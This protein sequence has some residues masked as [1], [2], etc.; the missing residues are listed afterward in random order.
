MPAP[1]PSPTPK[2]TADNEV[3]EPTPRRGAG[4]AVIAGGRAAR[5]QQRDGRAIE[6]WDLGKQAVVTTLPV[7]EPGLGWAAQGDAIV[8]VANGKAGGQ[9]RVLR[10][11]AGA[12]TPTVVTGPALAARLACVVATPDTLFVGEHDGLARL[13]LGSSVELAGYTPWSGDQID[14]CTGL[15]DG[16]VFAEPGAIVRLGAGDQRTTYTTTLTGILHLAAGPHPDQVWATTA[17]ALHLLALTGTEAKP[18]RDVV[19]PGIY[20]LAAAGPDAAVLSVETRAGAWEK[21]TLTVIGEGG[22]VRWRKDLPVSKKLA[23]SVAG[24]PGHVAVV[25]DDHLSVFARKD[26]ATVIP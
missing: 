4:A 13:R 12:T 21:L 6:I 26:G 10:L 9:V 15:G 24:G 16:V 8:I 1:S 20:H 11:A 23:A 19:L 3:N 14:T 22:A 7:P 25:A 2:G 5:F 17:G 18:V